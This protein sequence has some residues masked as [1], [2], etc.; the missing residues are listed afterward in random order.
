MDKVILQT[1]EEDEEL[2]EVQP[3]LAATRLSGNLLLCRYFTD[4]D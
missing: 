2:S 4:L 1:V 3:R